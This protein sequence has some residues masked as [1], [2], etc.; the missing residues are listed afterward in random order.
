MNSAILIVSSDDESSAPKKARS[1]LDETVQPVAGR[2]N[3]TLDD[4]IQLSD[5]DS[6]LEGSQNKGNSENDEHVPPNSATARAKTPLSSRTKQNSGSDDVICIEDDT[7]VADRGPAK[8]LN[9]EMSTPEVSSSRTIF[10]KSPPTV[11]ALGS[12]S[13]SDSGDLQQT[14]KSTTINTVIKKRTNDHLSPGVRTP[15]PRKRAKKAPMVPDSD[16]DDWYFKPVYLQSTVTEKVTKATSTPSAGA[17]VSKT[18]NKSVLGD[19]FQESSFNI[20]KSPARRAIR[21][22]ESFGSEKVTPEKNGDL[23]DDSFEL[24]TDCSLSNLSDSFQMQHLKSK[25]NTPARPSTINLRPVKADF[26]YY[27]LRQIHVYAKRY[28]HCSTG[29]RC[30]FLD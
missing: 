3:D 21:L 10:R 26:Y 4:I 20:L 19:A 6:S 25:E 1:E 17:T 7:P 5:L 14:H 23:S 15:T 27:W 12:E 9:F 13:S 16:E 28:R 30:L 18:A 2:P 24:P 22:D 29:F 11:I 8:H